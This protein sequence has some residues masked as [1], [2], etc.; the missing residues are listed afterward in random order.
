MSRCTSTRNL[1]VHHI[2]TDGGSG[3]EYNA[4]PQFLMGIVHLFD[5]LF[6]II[7]INFTAA[8]SFGKD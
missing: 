8:S 2:R 6:K 7:K 5:I 1:E 3:Q 4:S